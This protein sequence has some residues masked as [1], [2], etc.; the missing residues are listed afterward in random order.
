MYL[1]MI[2][3]SI[4]VTEPLFP[5]MQS[6]SPPVSVTRDHQPYIAGHTRRKGVAEVDASVETKFV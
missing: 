1:Q 3:Y 5:Q 4:I 6:I 2:E